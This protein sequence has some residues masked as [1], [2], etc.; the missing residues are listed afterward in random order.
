MISG[1]LNTRKERLFGSNVLPLLFVLKRTSLGHLAAFS[2]LA[3]IFF[4]F[5]LVHQEANV[6][7]GG[8]GQVGL[9]RP[10]QKSGASQLDDHIHNTPTASSNLEHLDVG[11]FGQVY[12][13]DEHVVLKASRSFE[14]PPNDALPQDRCLY[15]SDTIH[16]FNLMQD[17][18]AVSRILEQRPHPSIV[19]FIDTGHSEGIYLRRIGRF[20]K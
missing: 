4:F 11:A 12:R 14:P 20:P 6:I 1:S 15:A 2:R 16:H 18:L 10:S 13:V 17:E 19:Q 5:F 9:S 3:F 7:A 8:K